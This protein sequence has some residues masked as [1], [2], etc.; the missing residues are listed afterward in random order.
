MTALPGSYLDV[1]TMELFLKNHNIPAIVPQGRVVAQR[2]EL[3]TMVVMV[4]SRRV[5]EQ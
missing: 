1:N 4:T 5:G 2:G 3:E